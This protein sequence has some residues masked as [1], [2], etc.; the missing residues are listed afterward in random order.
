MPVWVLAVAGALVI[1]AAAVGGVLALGGGGGGNNS[2]SA[3]VIG[4][5]IL[6]RMVLPPSDLGAQFAGFSLDPDTSGYVSAALGVLRAG[7]QATL[8][9]QPAEIYDNLY[10]PSSTDATS[11]ALFLSNGVENYKDSSAAQGAVT[12]FLANP[13]SRVQRP[14]CPQIQTLSTQTFDPLGLG[15]GSG[16]TEVSV[17]EAS[18]GGANTNYTLTAIGFSVDGMMGR[19][20]IAHAGTTDFRAIAADMAIKLVA[21][22]KQVLGEAKATATHTPRASAVASGAPGSGQP[23]PGG[24]TPAGATPVVVITAPPGGNPGQPTPADVPPVILSLNCSPSTVQPGDTVSCAPSV[25]GSVS[26]RGWDAPGGSPSGSS[27][28]TFATAYG[29]PGVKTIT[30]SACNGQACSAAS[31]DISVGSPPPAAPVISSLGC[32]GSAETSQAIGCSPS[33]SGSVTA[34]SWSAPGGSPSGGG[35]PTFV[36]AFSTSGGFTITL[37]ACNGD[38]CTQASQG[39]T[40]SAPVGGTYDVFIPS[41]NGT[42]GDYV[43]VYLYADAPPAGIGQYDIDVYYD[44]NILTITGCESASGGSCDPYFTSVNA[45]FAG[46]LG[47]SGSNLLIGSITFFGVATGS[48]SLDISVFE[49]L[50]AAGNDVTGSVTVYTAGITIQ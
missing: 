19:V 46:N 24:E 18:V 9:P 1:A 5:D 13:A 26:V 29:S 10:G 39:V 40:V 36:T 22:I 3:E 43:T 7:C 14:G 33:I 48:S 42:Y 28:A 30:F 37:T 12:A 6:R 20:L 15:E 31:Q 35:D 38:A 17:S 44:P 50:D 47:Q 25:S 41:T 16:G 4:K 32:D 34:Y 21:R 2:A 23:S 27:S 11:D 45:N 8:N 49:M